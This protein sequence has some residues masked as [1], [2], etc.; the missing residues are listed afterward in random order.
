MP[1]APRCRKIARSPRRHD[2]HGAT[3]RE[4]VSWQAVG[5]G[6]DRGDHAGSGRPTSIRALGDRHL[7][8]LYEQMVAQPA[9]ATNASTLF[10][11]AVSPA[12][13]RC[14]DSSPHTAGIELKVGRER[15]W[16]GCPD[17]AT[18]RYH[19]LCFARL[20]ETSLLCLYDIF[21]QLPRGWPTPFETA[22]AKRI[23]LV[24]RTE[25]ATVTGTG[26]AARPATVFGGGPASRL[27]A[28]GAGRCARLFVQTTRQRP[29]PTP[30]WSHDRH[31]FP[32]F[33]L[34]ESLAPVSCLPS[35]RRTVVLLISLAV[36]VYLNT[37]GNA[38]ALR[39]CSHH[40]QQSKCS[41]NGLVGIVAA[42]LLEP[43]HWRRRQLSPSHRQHVCCGVPVVGGT[44]GRVSPGQHPAACCQCRLVVLPV[45]ALP[46]CRWLGQPGA[47]LFA[48]HP[49]HTEAVANIVGGLS[50]WACFLAD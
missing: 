33:R 15:R 24:I 6:D 19:V 12:T 1:K 35:P 41:P 50:C 4:G 45:E 3:N 13:G 7:P 37:L 28:L 48:V 42:R 22:L 32:D 38:F 39:R 16:A 46:G 36:V 2:T 47:A 11:T 20:G 31:T 27:R 5:Q 17:L 43:C 18:A 40:R 25:S 10:R 23:C 9:H 26:A 21:Q 14:K 44:S 30:G 34:V 29:R 8:K 49:V